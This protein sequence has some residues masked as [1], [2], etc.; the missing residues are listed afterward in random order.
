MSSAEPNDTTPV[1]MH[2]RGSLGTQMFQVAA[3][4]AFAKRHD[5]RLRLPAA[6]EGQR[7]LQYFDTFFN[8]VAKYISP[9]IVGGQY[10]EPTYSYWEIPEYAMDIYGAF[11]SGKYF[12]D[13][14]GDVRRLFDPPADF[15]EEV[16]AKWSEVLAATDRGIVLDMRAS[17]H[18]FLTQDYYERAIATA[19]ERVQDPTAPVF[20]FSDD[21]NWIQNLPW[22]K[23]VGTVVA[24]S[25]ESA[26]MWLMNQFRRFVLSNTAYSWWAAWLS[27]DPEVVV[28]PDAWNPPHAA[29]NFEDVYEDGWV[30]IPVSA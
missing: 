13:A 14:S 30:R 19:R 5:R 9:R 20:I 27:R 10:I 24:E 21:V 12:A 16:R 11:Q 4:Y 3:G 25:N 8:P 23:E 2:L 1:F 28:V 22:L 7:P 15:K 18:E 29:Q 6:S 26:T 17:S